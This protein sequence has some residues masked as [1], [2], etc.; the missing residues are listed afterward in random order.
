MT[1]YGAASVETGSLRASITVRSLNHRFLDL[2]LHL[3]RFLQPLEAAAKEQIA[4]A[5]A[6][7]RVE[8]LVN[9]ALPEAE[10]EVVVASRPLVASLVRTLRDM[11]N[12]HGL[13]GGVSVAD[14][15]RFPGALERVESAGGV[16]EEVSAGVSAL[17]GRALEGLEAMRGAEGERLRVELERLLAGIEAGAAR[18]EARLAESREVRQAALLE[19]VRALVGEIGLE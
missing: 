10:A 8:V 15:V 13:D 12:E 17:L 7:G 19:R 16:P 11:Q 1:G 14:L 3:P 2:V 4:A 6:R 18:V 9:A 5:V